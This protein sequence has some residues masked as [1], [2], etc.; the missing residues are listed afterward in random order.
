LIGRSKETTDAFHLHDNNI[1]KGDDK[2]KIMLQSK[3]IPAQNPIDLKWSPSP[4][5]V[6]LKFFPGTP[7]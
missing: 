5:S 7:E 6:H 1:H 3:N 2:N 4:Y